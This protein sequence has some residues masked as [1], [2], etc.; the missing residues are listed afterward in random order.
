MAASRGEALA[1]V[2]GGR[3]EAFDFTDGQDSLARLARPFRRFSGRLVATVVVSL[4]LAL[5][6]A[7]AG[8]MWPDQPVLAGGSA[9]A[10]L[11]VALGAGACWLLM[12]AKR[13][14]ESANA[15]K[16]RLLTA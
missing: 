8:A 6:I 3:H 2:F 7:A 11:L 1:S 9:G 14:A 12:R 13:R 16:T 4:T 5:V 15:A 10:L